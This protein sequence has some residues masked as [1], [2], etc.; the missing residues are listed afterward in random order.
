MIK[1]VVF[2][3]AG[4]TIEDDNVVEDAFFN[5]TRDT[6]LDIK[7]SQIKAVQGLPKRKAI[8]SLWTLKVTDP[9]EI[10][11]KTDITYDQFRGNLE[12]HYL[13][14]GARPARGAIYCFHWLREHNIRIAL[15]TGFYRKVCNIILEKLD[16]NKG[17][18]E[19][20]LGSQSSLIDLSL[21]PDETGKGRPYPDMI[22]MAMKR[23][24]IYDPIEVV[25]VGDTPVDIQAGQAAECL[26]NIGVTGGAHSYSELMQCKPNYVLDSLDQLPIILEK[27]L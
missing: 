26:L 27:Y 1:L 14:Y 10:E 7:R 13:T 25:K 20:Y 23:L 6:G 3:M 15:T 24:D 17:L 16:W 19:N 9:A 18:D 12:N 4:T 22:K 5:S 2:D 21:T 11:R 8:Q